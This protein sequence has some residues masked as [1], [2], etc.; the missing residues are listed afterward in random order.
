M[1]LR[2]IE[3]QG[4]E[5][6]VAKPMTSANT[7]LGLFVKEDFVY[8]PDTDAYRCPGDQFLSFRFETVEKE[9]Q[10]RYYA[11]PSACRCCPLKAKCTR[12]K[13][14]R[15]ITRW[16]DEHLLEAMAKRVEAN[17]E[18]MRKRKE[19]V[20]HPF[21]TIKHWG[22]QGYFLMRTLENV[23]AEFSLTALTYNLK[24]VIN[25][26]GVPKMIAALG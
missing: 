3:Q 18:M 2:I 14:G 9:R 21:G 10:I 6:Y 13:D 12:S 22:N 15:R 24:R 25:I 16:V 4:I 8:E 20:E 7:K 26:L 1:R 11:N 5:P 19:I 23:R 17:P